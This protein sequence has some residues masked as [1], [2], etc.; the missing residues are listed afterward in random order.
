MG[1]RTRGILR[2]HAIPLLHHALLIGEEG[3]GIKRLL[4]ILRGVLDVFLVLLLPPGVE[5]P[6][7]VVVLLVDVHTTHG[8]HGG[9][10][11][12]GLQ[13]LRNSFVVQQS[14]RLL[15]LLLVHALEESGAHF[16]EQALH[17]EAHG[18]DLR[19]LSNGDNRLG[20]LADL[21]QVLE[22]A[23]FV[24]ERRQIL[25]ELHIFSLAK[26][27]GMKPAVKE[28][29][30][31]NISWVDV[32]DTGTGNRRWGGVVEV[33]NFEQETHRVRERNT[34]VGHESKNLVIVHNGV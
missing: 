4:G 29:F 21:V 1:V 20:F 23:V 12:S 16:I 10:R 5:S 6:A 17:D 33:C 2:N 7:T 19:D 31:T 13:V 18:L 3:E 8:P 15:E 24:K 28:R 22:R 32:Q 9:I 25:P 14:S 34:F 27:L 30:G 26:L 11:E